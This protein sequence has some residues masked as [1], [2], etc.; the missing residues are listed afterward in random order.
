MRAALLSIEMGLSVM[1][2]E[3]RGVALAEGTR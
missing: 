2:G 1:D 3:A